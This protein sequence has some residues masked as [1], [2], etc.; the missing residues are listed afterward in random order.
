MELSEYTSQP[1]FHVRVY[2]EVEI[3][4]PYQAKNQEL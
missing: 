1:D 3:N 2:Q 4:S